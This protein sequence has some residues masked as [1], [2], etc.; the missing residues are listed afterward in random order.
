MTTANDILDLARS[1]IG[2]HENPM[3]SNNVVYNT[4]LYGHPVSGKKYPWCAAFV[5]WLYKYNK[6]LIHVFSAYSGDILYA[7]RRAGEEVLIYQARAGDIVIYDY[8]DGGR[9]DHIG[10]VEKRLGPTTFLV[11]EGNVK[12]A[13]G[14]ETRSASDITMWFTR[15]KYSQPI[16]PPIKKGGEEMIYNFTEMPKQVDKELG[17]VFVYVAPEGFGQ[18][19]LFSEVHPWVNLYNESEKP[20]KFVLFTQPGTG[21]HEFTVA[22]WRGRSIGMSGIMGADKGH[23]NT[24]IK[25]T[26][27]L[28]ITMSLFCKYL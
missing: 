28:S 12:D 7:G 22:G 24:I 15:P 13:V 21:R 20:T 17:E 16:P 11:I 1:Q 26:K 4:W 3:G 19:Y 10:V 5:S 18:L 14:R 27:P 2:V 8:G 6:D 23:F 25:S 9:T